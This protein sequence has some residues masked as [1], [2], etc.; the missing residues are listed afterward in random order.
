M[1]KIL[2]V[3]SPKRSAFLRADSQ[4]VRCVILGLVVTA[5][6]S[7]D[8]FSAKAPRSNDRYCQELLRSLEVLLIKESN[9]SVKNVLVF[10]NVF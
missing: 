6:R 7:S 10:E 4:W 8:W 2:T 3:R 5:K 9:R 1:L